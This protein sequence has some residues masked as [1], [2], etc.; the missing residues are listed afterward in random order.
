M[1]T[2]KPLPQDGGANPSSSPPYP[3]T[4]LTMNPPTQLP[5]QHAQNA[6]PPP[7]LDSDTASAWRDEGMH[8]KRHPPIEVPE[9]LRAGPPGYSQHGYE[10]MLRP[11]TKSTNPYL[12]KM[13]QGGE[14]KDSSASAWGGFVDRPSQP[15]AP[16]PPP[17]IA[18]GR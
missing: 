8:G 17:P 7:D 6:P 18:Q 11:T 9:S 16:P 3:V 5:T 13:A 15:S 10:D 14:S 1:V 12:Q 2:R 4:P